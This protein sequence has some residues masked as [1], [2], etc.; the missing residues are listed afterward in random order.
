MSLVEYGTSSSEDEDRDKPQFEL[1]MSG[2]CG[3]L[4]NAAPAVAAPADPSSEQSLTKTQV[5]S[6][7]KRI[8]TGTVEQQTVVDPHMFELSKR[9]NSV[10]VYKDRSR[11]AKRR[12]GN[13]GELEGVDAY[14]GPWAKYA[15]ESN[16]DEYSQAESENEHEHEHEIEENTE[17]FKSGEE[18]PTEGGEAKY[19][20]NTTEVDT[21]NNRTEKAY[22]VFCGTQ[23]LD[24]LGRT[25][26][27][28]P[29]DL[30]FS[31]KRDSGSIECRVPNSKNGP[32]HTWSEEDGSEFSSVTALALSP[33]HGHLLISGDGSGV[34]RLWDVFR[35]RELLRRF[36]GHT[37]AVTAIDF[38]PD[39]KQFLSSSYD[40]VIRL[41]DV[42]SGKCLNSYS[43]YNKNKDQETTKAPGTKAVPVNCVRIN[44]RRPGFFI[45]GLSNN[46]IVQFDMQTGDVKQ[47]YNH[48]LGAVVSLTFVDKNFR[49][50]ST[51]QDKTVRIWDWD[52]NV[53]VKYIAGTHQHAMPR[54]AAHPSGKYVAL[55][56]LDNR[57]V[58]I[59][60]TDQFRSYKNKVY[61][62]F[63]GAGYAVGLDIS[64]D[65][66]YL[67]A[68]DSTGHIVMWDWQQ[69]HVVSRF[70]AHQ[71]LVTCIVAH[72]Q[73]PSG[74][75]SGGADGTIHLWE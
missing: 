14:K 5:H 36:Y 71:K 55:Q 19:I 54:V 64:P 49:F 74:L 43:Y 51:S 13:V 47:E 45:A 30:G 10:A 2:T 15:S 11:H 37:R 62:G 73:L 16:S 24:Y 27:H 67:V 6:R 9:Q 57:I 39:G 61:R 22:S 32:V 1:K 56:S 60:A 70:K 41:W 23:P 8:L 35:N 17:A 66:H 18:D 44:P 28:V 33:K 29:Q 4:L 63:N 72:P 21:A 52:I 31:L 7:T 59:G 34:V 69:H 42:E 68:G 3:K 26:M 65:G 50:L 40:G 75:I 48:H 46:K 58:V 38:S 20:Y 53:P 12:K 25:Y